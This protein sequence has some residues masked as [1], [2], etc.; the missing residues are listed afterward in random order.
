MDFLNATRCAR[1]G[2]TASY[3]SSLDSFPPLPWKSCEEYTGQWRVR[4]DSYDTSHW[5]KPPHSLGS[6]PPAGRTRRDVTALPV[7]VVPPHICTSC[8]HGKT[9][10][11]DSVHAGMLD[12]GSDMS[13]G[14][15][16]AARGRT[17][18]E[19][20]NAHWA[21]MRYRC[22]CPNKQTTWPG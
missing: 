18:H 12:T 2:W 21:S 4:Y 3:S 11:H 19:R 5:G 7:A 20:E 13:V 6:I 8:S 10:L 14:R 1:R 17:V 22:R 16:S 15:G 9:F